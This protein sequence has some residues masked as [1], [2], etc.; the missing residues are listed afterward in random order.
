MGFRARYAGALIPNG[1]YALPFTLAQ[2]MIRTPSTCWDGKF[3]EYT[4]SNYFG[5][6]MYADLS[7]LLAYKLQLQLRQQRP[8]FRLSLADPTAA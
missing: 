6:Y 8:I 3:S 7:N 5:R 4:A 1:Q 2:A